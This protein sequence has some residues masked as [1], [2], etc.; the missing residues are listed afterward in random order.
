MKEFKF[1]EAFSYID[2][3]YVDEHFQFNYARRSDGESTLLSDEAMPR[4]SSA[5]FIG[6]TQLLAPSFSE[7]KKTQSVKAPS[8]D[9]VL[10]GIDESFSEMLLRKIDE[11]GITDAQCY[12]KDSI[13][14]VC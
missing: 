1:I 4:E 2:D 10:K 9:D 7:T 11:K 13:L 6:E 5:S 3:K 14:H 12:K 8:L